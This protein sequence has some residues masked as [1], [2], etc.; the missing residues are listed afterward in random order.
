MLGH[1]SN[2]IY[3]NYF[4]LAR[5]AYFKHVFSAPINWKDTALVLASIK[6]DYKRP[7]FFD[8]QVAVLTRVYHLGNKSLKMHQKLINKVSREEH[9]INDAVLVAYDYQ[10]DKAV[11]LPSIWKEEIGQF[12]R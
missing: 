9:A 1:V 5:T 6:I 11:A 12:E 2:S 8:E 4:D 7:I 3:Q 10:N